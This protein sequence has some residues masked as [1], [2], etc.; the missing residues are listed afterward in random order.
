[1]LVG[2]FFM[3]KDETARRSKADRLRKQLHGMGIE[4]EDQAHQTTW[5]RLF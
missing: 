1:M 5:R 2:G 4:L 3:P